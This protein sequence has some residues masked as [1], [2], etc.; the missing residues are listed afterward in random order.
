MEYEPTEYIREAIES[1]QNKIDL[2]GWEIELLPPE[3]GE[4]RNVVELDLSGNRLAYLPPEIGKLENLKILL[5]SGNEME[6]LN[7]EIGNLEKLI[8]LDLSGNI[9]T[10]LPEEIGNLKNLSELNLSGNRFTSLPEEIGKL[11]NLKA[12]YIAGNEI[13]RL[14]M[15]ISE[16]KNLNELH[17]FNNRLES[18]PPEIS[19]LENLRLLDV[20]NNKLK[21]LINEI[22]ELKNLTSLDVSENELGSLPSEIN[23]LKKLTKLNI[24]GNLLENL[25]DEIG[26]LKSLSILNAFENMLSSITPRIGNLKN[27]TEF[28]ISKNRLERLQI[29][30]TELKNLV[31]LNISVNHLQVLPDEIM[32]LKSLTEIDVSE[33]YLKELP[34]GISQL[35]NL[36]ELDISDNKLK[37]LP[38]EIG[39]LNNL[40]SLDIS[41]NELTSLPYE[42]LDLGLN[43]EWRK[44]W[45]KSNLIYVGGNPLEKPPIEV[46]QKGAKAIENYF[47]SVDSNMQKLSEVKVLLVGDGGSG[48]TSLVKR[49]LDEEIDENE[50]Q[51]HGI[52]IRKWT[53]GNEERKIEANFWDFGGQEIMHATHQFFLSKRNLYILVLDGRKDEK[54]EYW[55][56]LIE[57]FG[58]DSP[59]LV[60]INKI[61]ENPT[62]ELNRK[63]LKEKYPTIKVFYR[64]SCKSNEGVEEFSKALQEELTKVKHLEIKWPKSWFNVKSRFEKLALHC[65]MIEG[66]YSCEHCNFITYKEYKSICDEEGINSESEQDT[67]VDFLHDLGVIL[68]FRD[69]PL[70][71]T[72]VLEPEWVTTAVYKI[73]TSKKVTESKGVL[74]LDMLYEILKQKTKGEFYYPPEQYEFIINLMKKFELSYTLDDNTMLL[75]S[76]LEIQEPNFNFNYENVLMFRIDYDFL[77]LSVMPRFIVRMNQS[78]KDNLC[79]RTGVVLEDKV[80]NST[81]VVRADNEAKR[82]SIY[83]IGRRKRDFFAVILQRFREINKSVEKLKATEKIPLPDE[84][85]V[86]ISYN[87]LLTLQ[88]RGVEYFVPEGSQEVY[89]VKELLSTII[90]EHFE[91]IENENLKEEILKIFKAALKSELLDFYDKHNKEKNSNLNHINDNSR[92]FLAKENN[93]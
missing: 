6:Y 50:P 46:I 87:H 5:I 48:K 79:W 68:H 61:D 60:V 25:T 22:G 66:N 69:I 14:P 63:F 53:V 55:L 19:G 35:N 44:P 52:H 32:R 27:L 57:N 9:L 37:F 39:D 67:L 33:N 91:I 88:K 80:F 90:S 83:V 84:P 56:K 7:P 73:I 75:P 24:S 2:S 36:V 62:F 59:I 12:L 21:F 47:K 38:P 72:Y 74:K 43:I 41:E 34:I 28:N 10:S 58:G 40:T 77:P 4:L 42:I 31:R 65:P 11:K 16:L 81:A 13:T 78:I 30:I 15:E 17:I 64:L 89:S 45:K 85:E 51:T 1:D 20:S 92:G 23:K 70:L 76:L 54:A 8:K 29:E 71:N 86:T 3:I 93:D 49:L 82:I 18:L 26:D